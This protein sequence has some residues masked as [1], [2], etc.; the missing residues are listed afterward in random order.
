MPD[1]TG[2]H[3]ATSALLTIDVQNDFTLPD[4]PCLVP[5]TLAAVPA[6]RRIVTAFRKADLPIV[7]VVRLYHPD[8]SNADLPRRKQI[9]RGTPVVAPGTAG[10]RIVDGLGP[11]GE[12]TPDAELLLSGRL[13]SLGE[14][15][16]VM[17]KP[18][19]G[20][21]YATPLHEHLDDL[22]V[23]TVVACG[24]NFPNCPRTTIYEA[25]ERTTASP[26]S[27][28]RHLA[29]IRA[30]TR[31]STTSGSN[32]ST[33][34]PASSN[35][36]NS[37]AQA[38]PDPDPA[39]ARPPRAPP[40]QHHGTSRGQIR[41]MSVMKRSRRGRLSPCA[42]GSG[43]SGLPRPAIGDRSARDDGTVARLWS[44]AA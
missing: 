29:C 6:I 39:H 19:W 12:V 33:R 32:C 17:Y 20:A 35:S 36:N 14:R 16:R 43:G 24:C 13:Q 10:A 23:D 5:G 7:H 3:L 9:E 27:P 41:R 4:A 25:S 44:R 1:Y 26:W 18:R 22:G 38:Q 11:H 8:G 42:F 31:N 2:L 37:A 30:P 34:R 15:E 40:E 21:F 28:M